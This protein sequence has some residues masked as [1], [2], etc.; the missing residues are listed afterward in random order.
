MLDP[1]SCAPLN[2]LLAANMDVCGVVVPEARTA[3]SQLPIVNPYLTRTVIDIAREKNV[4]VFALSASDQS[5]LLRVI[6]KLRPDVACVAC[7]PQRIPASLLEMPAHGFLN[8]HPSLLPAYRGPAPLFWT[9]RNGENKTGVTIHFMDAT[10]DSGD[11]ALQAPIELPDGISG[12]EADWL[13]SNLGAKLMVESIHKLAQGTLPRQ[14]QPLAGHYD[15]WP[16]PSAFEIEIGWPARRV[17]NFMRG[18]AAWGHPYLLQIGEE[19][20]RLKAAIAYTPQAALSQ[21]YVRSGQELMVQF[22]PGVVRALL[23]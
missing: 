5:E 1:F 21:P 7:F 14:K 6:R 13:C 23:A 4:P 11:I 10:L 19:P 9:F 18:T 16:S 17:F 12:A 2:S 3:V 20:F 22:T 8:L 15:P